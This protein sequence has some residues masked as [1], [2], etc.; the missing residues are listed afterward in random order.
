MQAEHQTRNDSG[1]PGPQLSAPIG[2]I[3]KDQEFEDDRDSLTPAI[4]F[5]AP[6][7]AWKR[8]TDIACCLLALPVFALI[9]LVMVFV[10]KMV[11]PGPVFFKQL[12]IGYRQR[13]FMC[14][15]FRTMFAGADS[16]THQKHCEDLIHSNGPLVKMDA[17]NDSRVIPGGWLL[18]ASGLD[19]LPQLI[20]VLRGDMSLV[21]RGPVFFTN[22]SSFNRG[23]WNGSAPSLD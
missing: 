5:C 1:F 14:Y 16:K 9:T 10:T 17:R 4:N 21:D 3:T 12:R 7:P 6:M 20:N 22:M 23:I 19:E 11:S 15:K 2:R 8:A 13:R 18:R